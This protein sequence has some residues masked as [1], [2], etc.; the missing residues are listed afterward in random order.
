MSTYITESYSLKY[1]GETM[2]YRKQQSRVEIWQKGSVGSSYPRKIGD[3]RG[4]SLAINGNE[5]IDAPIVKTILNLSMADTWDEVQIE[6]A[7]A[8]K[9][10]V[11][12]EFY[13]PDS[14][15]YLVKLFTKEEGDTNWEHRWSGYITPD[16][17]KETIGY[18]GDVGIVARDN[19]GH[20][21]DFDFDLQGDS[22][23]LVSAY[24]IID[25]ALAKIAF[26][27]DVEIAD[28]EDGARALLLEADAASGSHGLF[29]ACLAVDNFK[30]ES[31]EKVFK[32]VLDSLGLTIRFVDGNTVVVTFI[33]NLSLCGNIGAPVPQTI[34]FYGAGTRMLVPA[35]KD[36]KV[37]TDFHY[38]QDVTFPAK[39]LG[40]Y[41]SNENFHWLYYDERR[42]QNISGDAA[43]TDVA[44]T[45]RGWFSL[46]K[47][48]V[49]PASY[50][51][52]ARG[53]GAA[54]VDPE[55][56]ALL[57]ANATDP[58]VQQAEA[59][60][61]FGKVNTPAAVVSLN[62]TASFTLSGRYLLRS[63]ILESYEWTAAY[64][65][66]LNAYWW[67]GSQWKNTQA[68]WT[69]TTENKMDFSAPMNLRDMDEGG[70]L[71]IFIRNIKASTGFCIG[72]EG[73][74]M[75]CNDPSTSLKGDLVT[76]V[77]NSSYNVR[78][79]RTPPYG[80]LSKQ[81]VWNVIG[82][83]PGVFWKIDAGGSI[84]PF[85]YQAV[86]SDGTENLAVP[87]QWAKQTL[88]FHHSTLQQIEGQVGVIQNGMWR[89]DR[90]SYYKG[91]NFLQQGGT[92][93]LLSGHVTGVSLRE[94]IDY[95]TLW[96][97]AA[98][99]APTTA[100]FPQA[101]GGVSFLITCADDKEWDVTGLPDWLT[102]S[103]LRG[104]GS[105]TVTLFAEVN[106]YG[107]RTRTIYIAG[108]PVNVSQAQRN[109]D[110]YAF[111]ESIEKS[112]D[113]GSEYITIQA[114]N[115][116]AWKVVVSD[117][118]WLLVNGLDEWEGVG[119]NDAVSIYVQANETGS[120]RTGEIYIYDGEDNLIQTIPVA[121]GVEGG[122]G[123]QDLTLTI[124]TNV[125]SP[126]IALTIEGE[127]VNYTPGMVIPNGLTVGVTVTKSGYLPV[128]DTF[129][130]STAT[131]SRYYEL[132]LAN[133]ATISQ[134]AKISSSAQNVSFTISDPSNHGWIIDYDA[135]LGMYISGGGVTSG[136][137]TDHGNYIDGTGN[138]VVYLSVMANPNASERSIQNTSTYPFYFQDSTTHTKTS[139]HIDQLGAVLRRFLRRNDRV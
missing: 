31:W 91:H 109:F 112:A 139:I 14:T 4:L 11:W 89:F 62:V 127:P 57:I 3:I 123:G 16:N 40:A 71:T 84:K 55:T 129:T 96:E 130:M 104:I 24:D 19:L 47:A 52:T 88:M 80:F 37:E 33:R 134:P 66:G 119:Y 132:L 128:T 98:T 70:V 107:T 30:G 135:Y 9:H 44:Q 45:G 10:G 17:W 100:A 82:N 73:V 111:P 5:D 97:G 113:G 34:E 18:R 43:R 122:G 29:D 15:A 13:T 36:V 115:D 108:V 78:A 63:G 56:T 68:V 118:V 28:E 114:S 64:V 22:D 7:N 53:G 72:V 94:Y 61:T 120:P 136:N 75:E 85:P 95:A 121:Q 65:V 6:S 38:K 90:P 87:V 21:Q 25:G 126:D 39:V 101:G 59:G 42:Q 131:S 67:N 79:K 76:V 60:Y 92:W 103:V 27:M 110:L 99:V 20:L 81:V 137:A 2:N 77:N 133:E 41:G 54:I 83:Y 125:S 105:G 32:D 23:G 117:D 93:D 74:K 35:Y 48:F 58:T 1:Y 86:W 50:F 12:E 138:A 116:T 46:Q 102:A 49:N 124:S 26:P 8:T 69:E 106:D 51:I